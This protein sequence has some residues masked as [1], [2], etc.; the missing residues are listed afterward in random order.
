VTSSG[1]PLALGEGGAHL[2]CGP[3]SPR[4]LRLI[5]ARAWPSAGKAEMGNRASS[6]VDAGGGG[7]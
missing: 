4:P 3:G 1:Q 5:R 2:A 6:A 7:R